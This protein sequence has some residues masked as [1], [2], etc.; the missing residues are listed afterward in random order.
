MLLQPVRNNDFCL[1]VFFWRME[2]FTCLLIKYY[3][4][5]FDF[6]VAYIELKIFIEIWL[7]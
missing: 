5:N 2:Q 3:Q 1:S 6:I 7:N 4:L